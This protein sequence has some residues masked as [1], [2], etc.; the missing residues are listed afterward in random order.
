MPLQIY[1]YLAF[2]LRKSNAETG[3]YKETIPLNSYIHI[4]S[5]ATN[6]HSIIT[7]RN[8]SILS[9][10]LQTHIKPAMLRQSLKAP[11]LTYADDT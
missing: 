8:I 4:L 3:K 9:G 5:F 6:R 2:T 10:G 1:Y 11:V 7:D